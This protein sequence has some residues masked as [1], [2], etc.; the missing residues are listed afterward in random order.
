MRDPARELSDGF[1]LLRLT[2]L[3]MQP[4][5][6]GGAFAHARFQRFVELPQIRFGGAPLVHVAEDRR[7]ERPR[8]ARPHGGRGVH[9]GRGSVLALHDELQQ[10]NGR[11]APASTALNA[12]RQAESRR[13]QTVDRL[14]DEV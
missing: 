3:F 6:I 13:E 1:H 11:R 10:A 8:V 12:C 9:V 5:K 7:D 2:E 14:A 4:L